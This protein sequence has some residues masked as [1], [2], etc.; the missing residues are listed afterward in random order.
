MQPVPPD[1]PQRP[2]PAIRAVVFDFGNVLCTFDVQL[3]A[4]NLARVSGVPVA[5]I[6]EG[7]TKFRDIAVR[8]ETGL[9]STEAFLE[10]IIE[11]TGV[12]VSS[13]QLRTAYCAIFA[14]IPESFELVR[15]LKPRYKL[16]LLS[17]TSELHFQ[18][19]IKPVEVFPLFDAVT[20]SFEVKA[21][22]PSPKIYRDML[23]KLALPSSD[24][25]YVD[26]L[27]D[28]VRAAEQLGFHATLYR[29]PEEL[30]SFLRGRGV[31]F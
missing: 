16:G 22:K 19:A 7:L 21:M 1:N 27:A 30:Q 12:R 15:R 28:N 25:V 2:L 24:C 29:S 18:C 11:R 20:L 5:Q 26:D 3:L 6:G 31:H 4:R 23:D 13:A 17:N 14:P 9:I 8:Y 10:G